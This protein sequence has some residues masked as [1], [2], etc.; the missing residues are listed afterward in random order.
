MLAAR[1][2]HAVPRHLENSRLT[3]YND[4]TERA[5]RSLG[6]LVGM[7]ISIVYDGSLIDFESLALRTKNL[8]NLLN[9]QDS[10]RNGAL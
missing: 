2:C 7:N 3:A 6:V 1:C 10:G 8:L 4:D 9:L 5:H